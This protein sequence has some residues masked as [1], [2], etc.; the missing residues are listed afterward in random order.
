MSLRAR[1]QDTL[2]SYLHVALVTC[3]FRVIQDMKARISQLTNIKIRCSK[4]LSQ[5]NTGFGIEP[6]LSG[7]TRGG[8]PCE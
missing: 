4:D 3:G 5:A 7:G 1:R 2:E 6:R 8:V